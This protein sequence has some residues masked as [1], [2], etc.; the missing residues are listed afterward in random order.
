MHTCTQTNAHTQKIQH[1][2]RS[3]QSS[4]RRVFECRR[5]APVLCVFFP[6]RWCGG[7]WRVHVC[8]LVECG[9]CP[10]ACCDC[11]TWVLLPIPTFGPGDWRVP[12]TCVR[13]RPP[14]RAPPPPVSAVAWR[15]RCSCWRAAIQRLGLPP[16]PT[17]RPCTT[18]WP[19]TPA[20]CPRS[21][22]TRSRRSRAAARRRCRRP[23]R[24]RRRR[25]RRRGSRPV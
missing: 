1:T 17:S 25:R 4:G 22:R 8:R 10:H 9:S 6:L 23:S 13:Q 12:Q 15:R 24:R 2:D 21:R 19:P 14:R 11:P 18:R 7:P 3:V 16:T 5:G 20:A